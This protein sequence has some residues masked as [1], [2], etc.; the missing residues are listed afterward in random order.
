MPCFSFW[1][2]TLSAEMSTLWYTAVLWTAILA[3]VFGFIGA[4]EI[5]T[6]T[7]KNLPS[8]VAE[9]EFVV[10]LYCT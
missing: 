8:F 3:G 5:E 9:T 2:S 7:E 4:S 1:Q 10:V 6:L